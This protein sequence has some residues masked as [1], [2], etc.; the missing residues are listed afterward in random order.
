[1]NNTEATDEVINNV[2]LM[3]KASTGI[4]NSEGSGDEGPKKSLFHES[5]KKEMPQEILLYNKL[6]I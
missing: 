2:M 3:R 5:N 1:M 6:I 4:S